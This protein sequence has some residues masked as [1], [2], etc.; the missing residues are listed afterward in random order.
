MEPLKLKLSG[1]RGIAS[2]RGKNSIEIDFGK[3]DGAARMVAL[4][5]PNGAGKTTIMDNMHPYRVMPSRASSPTPTAYSY[6]DDLVEGADGLKDLVWCHNGVIYQSV[7]RMRAAGKSK[8]QECYLFMQDATAAFV[9]YADSTGLV[10]DG[11][12]ESYDR[13]VEAVCGRPDVFFA[14]LFSAQGKR[15]ISAMTVSEVKSLLASMLNIESVKA[16]GDRAQEVV[17]GL[18][19][20]LEATKAQAIPL[21]QQLMREATL[22]DSLAGF[23]DRLEAATHAVDGAGMLERQAHAD[24]VTVEAAAGQQEA[25]KAQHAA[26]QVQLE[27][28]E[29][30]RKTATAALAT[31]QAQERTH[32]QSAQ[33]DLQQTVSAASKTLTDANT[34]LASVRSLIAREPAV[35]AAETKRTNLRDQ[36]SAK[37]M[38]LEEVQLDADRIGELRRNVLSLSEA[39]ATGQA[40][41]T[42]LANLVA[43]ATQTASLIND[44]PCKGHSFQSACK[45]LLQ[46]NDAA[47]G[48]PAST[49]KLEV[50]RNTFLE[51][52]KKRASADAELQKLLDA[53]KVH[54]QLLAD[55][56]KLNDEL[57]NART[58]AA[59]LPAIEEAKT[60]VEP[61]IAR[62]A[63]AKAEL[64]RVEQRLV[65]VQNDLSRLDADHRIAMGQLTA[66]LAA[67]VERIQ[68]MVAALPR[69]VGE[70]EVN[71]VRQ[72]L[73][74]AEVVHREARDRQADIV[75]KRQESTLVLGQLTAAKAELSK[76]EALAT[77]I[78]D[79]IASWTLLA[80]ALG[81]NGIVAMSIDDA[82]PALSAQC[83]SLLEDCYGGRFQV[84]LS[85]QQTTATGILKESFEVWVEDTHRGEEKRL[86][87][88]SGGEK[89]WINEC[90][91][92]S[93]ALY[94]AQSSQQHY[95]TLFC[96]EADGPLDE[97]RKRQFMDMKRAVLDRGGYRRE[98][99]VTQTPQLWDLCDARIDV[100]SL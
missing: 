80:A 70:A 5:G 51:N 28:S 41:G 59:E 84:R 48:L 6:Y 58:L 97:A 60:K 12:A 96:D 11:K 71:L 24:L 79:E 63:E 65:A 91:V 69:I 43:T 30:N 20:H 31:R 74:Q 1:F 4:V 76:V 25:V 100:G 95:S 61:G 85:T 21:Q 55:I 39:L 88:M 99:L 75:A 83:N 10:S 40:D 27:S 68:A 72:R 9:P 56:S 77:C 7:I 16:L 8:K 23:D 67:E 32:L 17:K 26:L 57:V 66:T 82:G 94:I 93:M 52:K 50:L 35:R 34:S 81:N 36:L 15:P 2:G 49:A 44:V 46:A 3:I 92:R 86:S 14:A 53:E 29:P 37:R 98:Y 22:R 42:A 45:L 64:Q 19:P 73:A 13:A 87:D 54:N 78:S 18:R 62:V 90:L 33:V 38:K 89:V 47:E